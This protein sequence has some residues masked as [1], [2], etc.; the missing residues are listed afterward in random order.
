MRGGVKDLSISPL[1]WHGISKYAPHPNAAR[2]YM[3]WL[4]SEE[5]A[6]SILHRYGGKP[7]LEGVKDTRKY[8]NQTW[9]DP[10]KNPY[11]VDFERW[12]K[13]YSKDFDLWIK[14]MMEG[15]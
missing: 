10:I 2:L 6:Q 8:V 1:N 14:T 7:S 9:Y 13:N 11:Y 5:G 4:T 15:R 3:N 12:Q